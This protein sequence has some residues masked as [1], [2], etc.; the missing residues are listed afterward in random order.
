MPVLIRNLNS[1]SK[2]NYKG[3]PKLI[4]IRDAQTSEQ[5]RACKKLSLYITAVERRRLTSGIREKY[6]PFLKA[7]AV[8]G[9]AAGYWEPA[10]RPAYVVATGD[11]LLWY[12]LAEVNTFDKIPYLRN[13]EK[14][15]HPL[16]VAL[17]FVANTERALGLTKDEREWLEIG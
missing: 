2:A 16:L 17:R 13:A 9:H 14:R 8:Y 7:D 5:Q 12:N 15:T 4:Q 11:R 6:P 3:N 10:P 1:A